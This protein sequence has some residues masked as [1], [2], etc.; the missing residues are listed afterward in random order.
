MSFLLPWTIYLSFAGAVVTWFAG[1]QSAA[2]AR[3]CALG[4]MVATLGISLVAAWGF[5]PVASPQSM[6]NIGWLGDWA[7]FHLAVDGI[8]LALV[9]LTGV[10]GVAGVLFSWDVERRAGDFFALFLLLLCGVYGVFLSADVF[11]LFVFYEIAIVPKYF[12]VAAWG[13]TNREYGAMKL[14]LYSFAGSALVLAGLVWM[15]AVGTRTLPVFDLAGF[16]ECGRMLP[17]ALQ[18]PL[19]ALMFTG[20]AVLAGMFPFHTWAPTGHV[21]APTGASMLLAGVV[22]KLGAYGCLRVALPAFPLGFGV[23][24]PVIAWLAVAGIVYAGLVAL[25]QRDFKFVIGYSSVSHM[26]FVLLGLAAASP[27]ALGGAVLQMFSHGVVAGLLFGVVGRMVYGRTH[28]RDLQWLRT[29]PLARL[30]PFAAVVF[31]LAAM[32]SMG[33]PGFSGFPAE[34][35][36]LS[37]VWRQEPVWALAAVVGIPV[38]AAFMLRA[39]QLAFLGGDGGGGG[40]R[41]APVSLP[42]KVG[43]GLLLGVSVG[44]GLRPD[45]LTGWIAPALES[46]WFDLVR[47]GG[48]Q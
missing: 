41:F 48:A 22:M 24:Q 11:L 10:A 40:V 32:A 34:L 46:P 26:G 47:N 9:L 1:A 27:L 12:L 4:T 19:F 15:S 5:V 28:S 39:L 3:W 20:F 30:M 42:E 38:G 45:V 16:V 18:V 29:L 13:S 8:S 31:A 23:F 33:M 7:R 25:V 21:A 2:R 35:A 17:V 43:A 37:G 44:V 36:I 14:V 6:V